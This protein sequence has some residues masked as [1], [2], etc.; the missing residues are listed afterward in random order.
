MDQNIPLGTAAGELGAD[1]VR[2]WGTW[3]NAEPNPGQF[4]VPYIEQLAAK[5]ADAKARG[6]KVLMIVGRTPAWASGGKSAIAPPDDP[7][8]FGRFMGELARRIAAVD[9]WELWNEQDGSEFW[10]GGP[11]PGVYAEMIKAAYPA[12]KAAQPQDLVVT[13]G[14]I[15]NDM[16]YLQQLYDHGA[17]GYFDAVGVHTDTACLTNSP[18][19]IYRDEKGRIGQYTFTGYREVHAV[20]SRHGDGAK[21]IWMTELGW[22]TQSSAPGSCSVGMWKGTKPLGVTEEEQARFLTQAYRCLAADPFVQTALWFGVQD[23]PASAHAG[24][25]GLY[26]WDKSA[27]PAAAAFKALDGGIAAQPCGGVLDTTGPQI[28][29]KKPTDGAKFV[30][31]FQL[32][33]EAVDAPGGVGVQKIEIYEDGKF[34]RSDG[35]GH[36][37]MRAYWPSREWRVGS[38]HKL[39]FKGWDEADN[40]TSKTITVTKVRR[41]PKVRT[42]ATVAVEQLDPA[43]FT[44]TGRVTSLTAH[45]SSKPRGKAFVVF[46]K[47]VAGKSGALV[48]KTVHRVRGRA[49]KALAVTKSLAPGNWRAFLVYP[50]RKGFKKSRSAPVT[51]VVAPA[52]SAVAA[53]RASSRR[54]RPRAR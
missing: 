50:G 35:D 14:L 18:D 5:T 41:L 2:V 12:I 21:P 37:V 1:W 46:Q 9:A 42:S 11:Q 26:R 32:D 29:I 53:P 15:G 48:W 45:A 4:N 7:A 23:I 52:S 28:V 13:G 51:F 30:G 17:Q 38:T 54:A 39:T 27:K 20:M 22:N 6:I 33:V 47:Q 43:T 25:F 40:T 36:A 24:G 8:N 44:V 3:E 49:R 19:F 10:L 16:D 31:E 34:S